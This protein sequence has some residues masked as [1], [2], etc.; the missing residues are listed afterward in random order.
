MAKRSKRSSNSKARGL[1]LKAAATRGA[2]A[3][4]EATWATIQGIGII[5]CGSRSVLVIQEMHVFTQADAKALAKHLGC[6]VVPH[7]SRLVKN[8]PIFDGTPKKK[9]TP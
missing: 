3:V 5:K 6:K 8:R 2:G 4:V 1:F 9:R 7:T